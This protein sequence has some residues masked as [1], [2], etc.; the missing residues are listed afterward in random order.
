MSSLAA[1]LNALSWSRA[2]KDPDFDAGLNTSSAWTASP[3]AART[4]L[5]ATSSPVVNGSDTNAADAASVNALSIDGEPEREADEAGGDDLT[6]AD[7]PGRPARALYAFDG[8]PEFRELLG[9]LAGDQLDVLREEVGDGWSLVRHYLSSEEG[10]GRVEVG[11]VP[12]SYYA[13]RTPFSCVTALQLNTL[14]NAVHSRLCACP[15]PRHSSILDTTRNTS[16]AR[17]AQPLCIIR[18][19]ARLTHTRTRGSQSYRPPNNW[20]VVPQLPAQPP[21]GEAAQ[22]FLLFRHQRRRGVGSARHRGV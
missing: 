16:F 19:T 1:F 14:F 4:S 21:W 12:C 3:Q 22:P 13:V 8:K 2:R 10:A 17:S 6:L 15:R 18:D 7:E 20:R 11:L 9:V 5:I